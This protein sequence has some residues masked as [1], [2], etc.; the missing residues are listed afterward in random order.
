[1][2][3]HLDITF[4][5]EMAL[6]ERN[7]LNKLTPSLNR[8]DIPEEAY[9]LSLQLHGFPSIYNTVKKH[10][11]LKCHDVSY[12]DSIIYAIRATLETSYAYRTD[13]PPPTPI[14]ADIDMLP[15][16][17]PRPTTAK[18]DPVHIPQQSPQRFPKHPTW[19]PC[20][21]EPRRPPPSRHILN[22]HNIRTCIHRMAPML[23]PMPNY[24]PEQRKHVTT[25]VTIHT[26]QQRAKLQRF[27]CKPIPAPR[28]HRMLCITIPYMPAR[29]HPRTRQ[30]HT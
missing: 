6:S 1:M 5:I 22:P 15:L 7:I 10:A 20:S 27:N 12:V 14:L 16:S 4:N 28:T 23:Q 17:N 11:I 24:P 18:Y 30:P 9:E 8:A 2:H 13:I 25:S 26:I 29:P 3:L 21:R 19:P